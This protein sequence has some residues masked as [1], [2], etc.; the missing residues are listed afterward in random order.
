MILDIRYVGIPIKKKTHGVCRNCGVAWDFEPPEYMNR[1]I[2]YLQGCGR[3]QENG[4]C[5]EGIK[6]LT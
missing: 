3:C 6:E 2:R 1:T 5:Y 4:Y